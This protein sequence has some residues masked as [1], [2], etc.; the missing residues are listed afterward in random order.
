M[1]TEPQIGWGVRDREASKM[2]GWEEGARKVM[3]LTSWGSSKHC[4]ET[5]RN[6]PRKEGWGD[7]VLQKD[8][9]ES[10]TLSAGKR[11][12][13][14]QKLYGA[15]MHWKWK[16]KRRCQRTLRWEE[17]KRLLLSFFPSTATECLLP[18]RRE[19]DPISLHQTS[20]KSGTI[21]SG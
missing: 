3:P 5:R 6:S 17:G 16:H 14:S 9:V 15:G 2:A 11:I 19:A 20:G 18:A 10:K 21:C 12:T 7:M 1:R 8:L 4:S 13:E